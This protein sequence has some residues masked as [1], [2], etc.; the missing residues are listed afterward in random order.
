MSTFSTINNI[1][2][3]YVKSFISKNNSKFDDNFSS[4]IFEKKKKNTS[5]NTFNTKSLSTNRKLNI[6]DNSVIKSNFSNT[7]YPRSYKNKNYLKEVKIHLPPIKTNDEIHPNNAILTDYE[8]SINKFNYMYK[9]RGDELDTS[10]ES[11]EEEINNEI[12]KNKIDLDESNFIN[13]ILKNNQ[14]QNYIVSLR[15]QEEFS[16]PKNSLYTIKIN[17]ALMEDISQL[18]TKYQYQT[19]ANK[20][21]E[22]Q[23]FRLKLYIMPKSKVKQLKLSQIQKEKPLILKDNVKIK[24]NLNEIKT[25]KKDLIDKITKKFNSKHSKK[26]KNKEKKIEHNDVEMIHLQITDENIPEGDT[27]NTINSTLIRNSLILDTNLYYFKYLKHVL[28]NPNSRME[29]TFTPY[30]NTLFLFGGLQTNNKSDLWELEITDKVYTWKRRDI[31]GMNLNPR[32]GHTTVLFN[33]CLYIY[34]GKFNIKKLKYPLEDFLL[35]HI[36]S[37]SMK[38]GTF[39]NHKNIISK[40]FLDIPQRRNHISQVIGCYMVVHGGIDISIENLRDNY[41]EYYFNGFNSKKNNDSKISENVLDYI[42]GDFMALDLITYKWM[43]I[44]N[45]VFKKKNSKKLLRFKSLPR[46]YHSSCLV[47][48]PE[49]KQGGAKINMFKNDILDNENIYLKSEIETKTKFDV[50]YEGIYIFGGLD[51]T[52]KET[53]NLYILHCFRNPLVLFEPKIKGTPPCPRQMATMNVNTILYYIIIYGGKNIQQ[54]FGDIFILDIMNFQWISVK[55]FGTDI[56]PKLSGHCAGIINNKLYIFGGSDE[57]NKYSSA[58]LLCIELDLIRNRKLA[59]IYTY[60]KTV[61]L[62]NPRDR[63]AKHVMDLLKDGADLPPDVYPFLQLD[64]N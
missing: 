63:L 44:N 19:Y 31:D 18:S 32:F 33:D 62:E 5:K 3:I 21:N 41:P 40:N 49:H 37:N 61:L 14:K 10:K 6:E 50:K 8:S 23:K 54:V 16:S 34:G 43:N 26:E 25:L 55:L 58:K 52:F 2:Q 20:I 7:F 28:N 27:K 47:L 29:A 46:V 35:Y 11:F 36:P 13:T 1:S 48:S 9:N 38:I 59:R 57:D 4:I 24:E 51:G 12:K 22:E 42:L 60:A 30:E 64:Q 45:I 53:N 15:T 39:K 56:K 17:K